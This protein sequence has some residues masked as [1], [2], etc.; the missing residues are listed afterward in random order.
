MSNV[1]KGH[2]YEREVKRLFETDGYTV[3][4]SAS[5]NSP[6]DLVCTKIEA[7]DTKVTFIA[8]CQCKI[9]KRRW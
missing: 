4:R 8:L 6:Y 7:E 5:S 9:K 1:S 3:T 2:D